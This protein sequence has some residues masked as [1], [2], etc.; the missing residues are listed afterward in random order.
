MWIG[1]VL[2]I[3]R[4]ADPGRSRGAI[5]DLRA[6]QQAELGLLV[7]PVALFRGV[8]LGVGGLEG[9]RLVAAESTV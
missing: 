7:A 3:C 2:I 4:P 5:E 9:D 6:H 1:L 8:L